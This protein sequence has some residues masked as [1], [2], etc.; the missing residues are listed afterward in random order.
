[1]TTANPRR[2]DPLT[3]GAIAIGAYILHDI[4]HEG[5]GHGGACLAVGGR[6]IVISTVHMECSLDHRLVTAG[7]TLVNVVAGALFFLL[8]RLTSR[9]HPHLKYFC[10][11]SMTINLFS[12]AGYFGFSGIAGIGDWAHFIEGFGP[13]LPWRIG[14]TLLGIVT[15]TLAVYASLFELRP[16]I[17]SDP[18]ERIRRAPPLLRIP[19]FTGGTLSCI[20][21]A[22]N[23]AGA[24][25][26]L[27]SAAASTF[28]GTSG[29]LW[30]D[31]L[32]KGPGIPPGPPAEPVSIDRKW[33]WIAA[34]V[35]LAPVYISWIGPGLRFS[36]AGN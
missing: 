1:M 23:P 11:L 28:G 30:M 20:A 9:S 7:G 32:L 35:F 18:A 2:V 16:I 24:I 19:Y 10:W 36:S 4:L 5:V 34:A 33:S 27:I 25:L 22:F 17:G 14:L 6:I 15:Y 8:G 12:A 13:E 31:Q 29:L 3:V 26:I 21:G